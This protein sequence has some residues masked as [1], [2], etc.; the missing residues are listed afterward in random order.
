MGLGFAYYLRGKDRESYSTYELEMADETLN[1]LDEEIEE[2][3]N[4]PT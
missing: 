3:P 1:T 2:N 4:P